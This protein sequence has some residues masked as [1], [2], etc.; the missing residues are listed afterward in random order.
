V[1]GKPSGYFLVL[2]TGGWV[3]AALLA[4]RLAVWDGARAVAISVAVAGPWL[5]WN[6]WRT[7]GDVLG[8]RHYAAWL[9][10]LRQPF[11]PGIEIPNAPRLFV[12]WL[13]VSSFAAFR[14][15]DLHLPTA[16]YVA[17]LALLSI[18]LGLAA[19]R[20]RHAT[21]TPA[22]RRGLTWLVASIATNL[23]L[24][25]YN[26][27]FVGFSPQGRY[28]ILMVVLLTAIA[29]AGPAAGATAGWRRGWPALYVAFLTVAALWSLATIA[30]NPC[31]G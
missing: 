9:A 18:G 13:S 30:A 1:L 14:N 8:L 26:C 7:G 23:G 27:W 28:V 11:T 24:V 29:C 22:D 3:A 4:R 20:A 12:E 25:V 16:F 2:T 31:L 10:S 19:T 15:L 6:A 5:A 17:A 21:P